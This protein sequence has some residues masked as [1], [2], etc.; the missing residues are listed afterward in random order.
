MRSAASSAPACACAT[1][2][3]SSSWMAMKL[4]PRTFQ[5]ACLP[6]TA[7]ACSPSVIGVRNWA[8]PAATSGPAAVAGVVWVF[9]MSIPSESGRS[10]SSCGS[11]LLSTIHSASK[12]RLGSLEVGT[13]PYRRGMTI[14]ADASVLS[15]PD[16]N[17]SIDPTAFVA[18]GARVIGAVTLSEGASV[19][20]NAVLRGD[21]DAITIG[22]GSN[23][24]D[25]VSVHVDAGHPDRHRTQCVRRAQRR[26]PR[27]H[28]RRRL[29]DRDGQRRAV[30]RCHRRGMPRRRRCGRARERRDPAGLTGRRR[31]REGPARAHAARSARGSCATPRR[32]AHTSRPTSRP[33]RL[34]G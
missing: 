28:D 7:S 10:L 34:E 13:L 12:R 4:A 26:R 27:L 23:L 16:K 30:G 25:N 33:E 31:A 1:T 24:Q 6:F 29:A 3:S 18:S 15:L 8:V 20:Y 14:A 19:W 2:E 5:C 9:V 22:A 21:S 17:P 11:T 32:T